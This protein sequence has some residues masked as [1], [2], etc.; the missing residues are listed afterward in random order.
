MAALLTPRKVCVSKRQVN[1]QKKVWFLV[2]FQSKYCEMAGG[3]L[4]YKVLQLEK[5]MEDVG[6]RTPENNK[7]HYGN[8]LLKTSKSGVCVYN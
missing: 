8:S 6:D 5:M 1:R 4:I 7:D 2:L 3:G